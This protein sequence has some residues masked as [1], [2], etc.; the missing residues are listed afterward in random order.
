[1]DKSSRIDINTQQWRKKASASWSYLHGQEDSGDEKRWS[2]AE[3]TINTIPAP[4]AVF[5]ILT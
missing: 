4:L 5:A 1:M 2:R 3:G